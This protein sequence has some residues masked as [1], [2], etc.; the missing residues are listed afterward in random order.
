MLSSYFQS[1]SPRSGG[2][3]TLNI[4]ELENSTLFFIIILMFIGAAPASV[5]GGIKITTFSVLLASM[6]ALLHGRDDAELFNRRIS[7]RTVYKAFSV[8]FISALIVIILTMM[9]SIHE[10][11]SFI[12]ILFEVVSAFGTV[13][14][15]TGITASLTTT[16]KCWLIAAMIA[17][18]VGPMT[19]ALALTL[20]ESKRSVRYPEGKVIIG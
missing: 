5:G 16:S 13:G 4:N 15:S 2:F 11:H 7:Y 19:L 10:N 20:R 12:A 6:W 9:L 3:N 17:G 18:R 14:L 1:I 8:L